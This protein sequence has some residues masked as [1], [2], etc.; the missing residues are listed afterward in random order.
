MRPSP[1]CASGSQVPKEARPNRSSRRSASATSSASRTSSG[2]CIMY[3]HLGAGFYR[4]GRL[5]PGF[6]RAMRQMAGG[7]GGSPRS[8]RSSITLRGDAGRVGTSGQRAPADRGRWLRESA[9]GQDDELARWRTL[10]AAPLAREH[11]IRERDANANSDVPMTA[12]TTRSSSRAPHAWTKASFSITVQLFQRSHARG[13]S[14]CVG[15]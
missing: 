10:V 12:S 3:T 2:L 7:T 6:E 1:S 15:R 8:R 13:T 5:D 4:S 11:A 14:K 9:L